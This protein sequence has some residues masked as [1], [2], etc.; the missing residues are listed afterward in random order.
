MVLAGNLQ[1]HPTEFALIGTVWNVS[2]VV[3]KM[4]SNTNVENRL[5]Y[6]D[7]EKEKFHF[8]TGKGD[9]YDSPRF[10]PD[11]SKFVFFENCLYSVKK[12]QFYPGIYISEIESLHFQHNP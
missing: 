12:P 11:G 8:I 4:P 7:L 10:S 6:L 3:P 5:F 1:W 9:H 2:Q